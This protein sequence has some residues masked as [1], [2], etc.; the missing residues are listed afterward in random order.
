[1]DLNLLGEYDPIQHQVTIVSP[2][3][4]LVYVLLSYKLVLVS[5]D[6]KFFSGFEYFSDTIKKLENS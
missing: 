2:A 4:I 5:R 6:L 1:M 3:Q